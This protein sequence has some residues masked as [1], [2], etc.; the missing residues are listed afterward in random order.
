MRLG[1]LPLGRSTFDV[2]YAEE[3][4]SCMLQVL[5]S[6]GHELLGPDT[7][8]YDES[9]TDSAMANL[10]TQSLDHLL[11]L[12]VTFTDSL[13]VCH[14]SEKFDCP[15]SIWS[16]PEPRLG[17]RLR[18]NS[19]CGLNL[20]SHALSLRSKKFS[21]LYASVDSSE[22]KDDLCA[23]LSGERECVPL[24]ASKVKNTNSDIGE[25]IVSSLRGSRIARI[26]GSP[27]RLRYLCVLS[28]SFK[29]FI[30]YFC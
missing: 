3:N 26:G 29:I 24:H 5:S 14:A 9:S 8:L 2:A 1:I 10:L 30:R 13:S 16:I 18:L 23:L 20:A 27:I 19:F 12:Q 6:L 28:G 25:R 7:L 22:L 21:W 17:E 4:L 15:L 11:I